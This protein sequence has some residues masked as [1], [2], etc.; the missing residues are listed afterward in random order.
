[1]R[2]LDQRCNHIREEQRQNQYEND[3]P[4]PVSD[5]D[6]GTDR[7]N[8]KQVAQNG[9]ALQER[10]RASSDGDT[11][12]GGAAVCD[13]LSPTTSGTSTAATPITTRAV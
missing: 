3:A 11:G 13:T 2:E 7:G 8:D 9:A 12:S 1:L 10:R 5:P 4:Q 6:A